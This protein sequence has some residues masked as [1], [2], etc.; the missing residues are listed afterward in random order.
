LHRY[1]V[2]TAA[3]LCELVTSTLLA[4]GKLGVDF[5]PKLIPIVEGIYAYEGPLAIP[6][7]DD[8]IRTNSLIVLTDDGVVV[9]DGQDNVDEAERMLEAIA[10]V[11]S[12]PVR[13]LI[14]A[15][16]HGDHVNG[17]AAFGDVEIVAQERA[18]DQMSESRTPMPLPSVVYAERMTLHVGGKTLELH[19]FGP[20]HTVG[21][22]VVYLPED[23]VA[24]LSEVYFN[25]IFTS[26]GDGFA[27]H[28][29]EVLDAVEKLDADWFIPG[30][31]LIDG[32][33]AAELRAGLEKYHANVKAV[34]DAVARHVA[35]G[36]SLEKTMNEIDADLGEFAELPFYDFLKQRTVEATYEAL[37]GREKSK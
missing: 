25:G 11:T 6:G 27:A 1:R 9:V 24:F 37:S 31:G 16:P 34:H 30:H 23:R 8:V 36:D 7:R 4:Q 35:A 3:F 13:Y 20:A 26:L 33:S 5:E 21:D 19:H 17:N 14:N 32:Q 29:L 15:S 12:Q 2:L 28:H 18:R 22:T 10:S